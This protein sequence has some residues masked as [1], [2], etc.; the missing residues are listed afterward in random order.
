MQDV[1]ETYLWKLTSKTT[2]EMQ[3]KK[4]RASGCS[5]ALLFANDYTRLMNFLTEYF[6]EGDIKCHFDFKMIPRKHR[7]GVVCYE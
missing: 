7:G 2:F 3:N 5:I 6:K 4:R 1:L